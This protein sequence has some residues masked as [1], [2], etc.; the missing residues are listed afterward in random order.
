MSS[1]YLTFEI[2]GEL[3]AVNVDKV[4]E[5]LEMPEIISVPRAPKY[6]RGVANLRG[7]VVPIIDTPIKFGMKDTEDTIHTGIIVMDIEINDD[8]IFL[9]VKV[10]R[11]K[12]VIELN[13]DDLENGPN[14]GM[15]YKSEF[16]ANVG[17]HNDGFVM[18][19]DIDKIFENDE[20]FFEESNEEGVI[21]LEN[22]LS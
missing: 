2:S 21:N 10:D 5:I 15:K 6:M 4:L 11:V 13:E 14:I 7:H 3:F 8:S 19:L 22:K 1:S 17:K 20:L 12:E 16:I 18:I 9:G